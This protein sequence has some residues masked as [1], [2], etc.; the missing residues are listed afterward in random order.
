[1]CK[2]STHTHPQSLF[3]VLGNVAHR[4][5][6]ETQGMQYLESDSDLFP[7]LLQHEGHTVEHG[8]AQFSFGSA[9]TF[10]TIYVQ[11]DGGHSCTVAPDLRRTFTNRAL[12]RA[13]IQ[14]HQ[15]DAKKGFVANRENV[16]R[17]YDYY[18]DLYH[19][20]PHKLLWAGLARLGGLEVFYPGFL[21]LNATRK[22]A[23]GEVLPRLSQIPL[24]RKLL[25]DTLP[26][27]AIMA[28]LEC[29]LLQ[30]QKD[31][32]E[33]LAWQHEAYLQGRI[34]WLWRCCQA[35]ILQQCDFEAWRKID[36]DTCPNAIGEG[37]KM[38][39]WR[40]QEKIVQ[41]LYDTL[42]QELLWARWYFADQAILMPDS[43]M[44]ILAL[45]MHKTMDSFLEFVPNGDIMNLKDRWQWIEE[46]VYNRW[47]DLH[48]HHYAAINARLQC[49]LP[50]TVLQA[51]TSRLYILVYEWLDGKS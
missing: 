33:D 48:Q 30:I 13:G 25:D 41:P 37:N 36:Q 15:W 19:H 49:P 2:M 31:I 9:Q 51:M 10:G 23:A 22:M 1:M 8:S 6:S 40:E 34:D 50:E 21:L 45:A 24:V 11:N 12:E 5:W 18:G 39:V 16:R 26:E 32:F 42:Q 14:A 35:D 47:L 46:H 7:L 27:A 38:L 29:R 3:G 43:A 17:V 4:N 28:A 44:S 20:A